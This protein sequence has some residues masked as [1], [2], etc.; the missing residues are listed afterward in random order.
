MRSKQRESSFIRSRIS[1]N[2]MEPNATPILDRRPKAAR[3]EVVRRREASAVNTPVSPRVP[4][5]QRIRGRKQARFSFFSDDLCN[6]RRLLTAF[7]GS[8]DITLGLSDKRVRAQPHRLQT[9]PS[10]HHH[11]RSVHE[12][13]LTFVLLVE[14]K[15]S[16]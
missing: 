8:T 15:K 1:D 6:S 9:R 11:S 4:P 13:T 14:G 12:T 5:F 2:Q 3:H 7:V 16:S 10:I